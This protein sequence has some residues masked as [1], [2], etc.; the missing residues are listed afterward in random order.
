M[1]LSTVPVELM[2]CNVTVLASM[3]DV[4]V[5]LSPEVIT[6]PVLLGNVMVLSAVGSATVSVVSKSSAVAPSNTMMPLVVKVM[7][8]E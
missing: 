5:P 2:I 8:A 7:A 4:T 1:V 6:V 3:V